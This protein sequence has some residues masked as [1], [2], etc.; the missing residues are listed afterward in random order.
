MQNYC[1]QLFTARNVQQLWTA[2]DLCET[3]ALV[4]R[5]WSALHVWPLANCFSVCLPT[6]WSLKTVTGHTARLLEIKIYK[7]VFYNQEIRVLHRWFI[8]PLVFELP[9]KLPL[10]FFLPSF[11]SLF[12]WRAA[13]CKLIMFLQFDPLVK[14][15]RL[16][17]LYPL[18]S[19][20][21]LIQ[22][23]NKNEAHLTLCL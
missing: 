1:V 11:C 6:D 3:N 16:S 23:L 12:F 2:C 4:S 17:T 15:A 22:Y 7:N 10:F 8:F 5:N 9:L 19:Y 14:N 20:L 18:V 21:G 13:I